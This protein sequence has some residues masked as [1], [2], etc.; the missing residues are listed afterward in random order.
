MKYANLQYSG[1]WK[2]LN[3]PALADGKVIIGE[4]SNP[5]VCLGRG[6]L[7]ISLCQP[8]SVELSRSFVHSSR[9]YQWKDLSSL[10]AT[11]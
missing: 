2:K 7:W 6:P 8:D 3:V 4:T 5:L 11:D 1:L 10:S 9:G